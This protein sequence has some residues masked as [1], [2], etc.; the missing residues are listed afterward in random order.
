MGHFPPIIISQGLVI[1][2]IAL[3]HATTQAYSNRF[4]WLPK[5]VREFEINFKALGL[6]FSEV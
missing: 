6:N 2:S 1:N 3:G 4:L 5:R